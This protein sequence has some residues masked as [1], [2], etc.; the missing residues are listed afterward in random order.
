MFGVYRKGGS[1]GVVSNSPVFITED[2]E[3]AKSKAKMYRAL[4]TAGE[5]NY[6][7]MSYVVRPYKEYTYNN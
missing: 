4:L 6:Y 2:K 1:L 7:K 3:L 5:R